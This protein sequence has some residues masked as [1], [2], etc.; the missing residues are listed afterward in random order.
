MG[1]EIDMWTLKW[2]N[3]KNTQIASK[4]T[5]PA[6]QKFDILIETLIYTSEKTILLFL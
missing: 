3:L 6:I 2:D 1:E 4:Q 5:F